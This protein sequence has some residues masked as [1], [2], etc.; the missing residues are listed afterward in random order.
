MCWKHSSEILVH[1]DM[2]VSRNCCRFVGCTSMMWISRSTTSQKCSIGFR[3]GDGGG[4]LSKELIV[5]F[6]KPVWDDL[7]FVTWC[8][9]LLEVAIRRWVHCRHKGMH[10]NRLRLWTQNC[11][12]CRWTT[13][14]C[15][16]CRSIW[17][18][19]MEIYHK[20]RT[21]LY[22]RDVH[23]NRI[24]LIAQPYMVSNNTQVGCGI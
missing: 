21:R 14:L 10:T 4:H 8:I 1:I 17:K 11:L 18:Q 5:M 15:S 2:I 7:S 16:N 23:D 20:S 12:A 22:W 9:I 13:A 24:R 6:K 19:V 3:S